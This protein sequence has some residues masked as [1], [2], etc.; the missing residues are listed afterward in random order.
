MMKVQDVVNKMKTE[1]LVDNR[2]IYV[3]ATKK[4]LLGGAAGAMAGLCIL[5][6]YENTLYMHKANLDNSYGDCIGKFDV[7]NMK[8]VKA[9]AGLFGGEFA[10]EYEGQKY[11]YKLPSKANGFVKFFEGK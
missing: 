6:V 7:A 5:S 2:E 8:I 11:K 4:S 3:Y 9:K 10:F 1:N